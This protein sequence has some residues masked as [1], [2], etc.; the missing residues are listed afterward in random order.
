MTFWLWYWNS[1]A[2]S[3]GCASRRSF[4][5]FL[6]Q[7]A[8]LPHHQPSADNRG[9]QSLSAWYG[10]RQ[11][12]HQPHREPESAGN[13]DHCAAPAHPP[14]KLL[15]AAGIDNKNNEAVPSLFSEKLNGLIL[16]IFSGNP[17][18]SFEKCFKYPIK[19][20]Q[21]SNPHR[22]AIVSTVSPWSV[23]LQQPHSD[24]IHSE[25]RQSSARSSAGTNA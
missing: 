6:Q 17:A 23:A 2:A 18:E 1:S 3:W 5:R 20:R 15:P 13:K 25:K 4:H 9:R 16:F 22:E 14:G 12:D 11:P 8:V 10:G 7:L 21:F 24:G 19:I